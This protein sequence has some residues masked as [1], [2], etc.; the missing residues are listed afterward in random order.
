M[1]NTIDEIL[2]L[3]EKYEA[4]NYNGKK[5]EDLNSNYIFIEGEVPILLSAPHAVK[6]AR[7]GEIKTQDGN[8]GGITEYLCKMCNCYGIIRNH[9]ELDDPNVDNAGLGLKYKEKMLSIIKQNNIKSVLDIHGCNNSHNF[10]F[11]IGTNDG[12]NLNGKTKVL[13]IINTELSSIGKVVIDD[14]FK[15]SKEGNI[16][17]Y[18]CESAKVPSIQLEIS[19]KFRT[20][21][22]Y[23]KQLINSLQM[24]IININENI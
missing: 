20:E 13:D 1:E 2:L 17:K 14:T 19:T 21:S 23:L 9:N 22:S 15:A 7:L 12:K 6:Q 10:D 11:C 18:V 8:T 24:I 4:N 5:I 3:N 16:S